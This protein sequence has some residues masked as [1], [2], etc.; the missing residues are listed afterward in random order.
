M[1]II[2]TVANYKSYLQWDVGEYEA[3]WLSKAAFWCK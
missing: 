1:N 3:A 2:I